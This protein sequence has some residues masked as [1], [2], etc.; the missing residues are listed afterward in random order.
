MPSFPGTGLVNFFAKDDKPF[1]RMQAGRDG[2]PGTVSR[3]PFTGI[4][5]TECVD[6]R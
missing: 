6:L 5:A 4:T 1:I 2:V 3:L